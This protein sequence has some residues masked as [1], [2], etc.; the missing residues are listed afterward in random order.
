MSAGYKEAEVSTYIQKYSLI[1]FAFIRLLRIH[2][3]IYSFYAAWSFIIFD[4][5]LLF[6]NSDCNQL[7]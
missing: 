1:I 4:L 2:L 3:F 7:R 5:R 6:S